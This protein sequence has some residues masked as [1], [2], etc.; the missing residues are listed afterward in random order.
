MPV[1]KSDIIGKLC[2]LISLE[3]QTRK[4]SNNHRHLKMIMQIWFSLYFVF[5]VNKLM[6][7]WWKMVYGHL[8]NTNLSCLICIICINRP[9]ILLTINIIVVPGTLTPYQEHP[10]AAN[11]KLLLYIKNVLQIVSVLFCIFHSTKP[12]ILIYG[13]ISWQLPLT[14]NKTHKSQ[15]QEQHTQN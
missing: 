13:L 11:C 10:S 15:T 14:G 3:N 12:I 1:E 2:I 7:G 9:T 8:I 4:T 5:F 6:D